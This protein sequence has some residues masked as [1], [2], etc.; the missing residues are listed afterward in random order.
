MERQ[1]LTPR[2]DW[3][4]RCAWL[5]F[6]FH[7]AGGVPYW[8]ESVCYRFTEA[9]IDGLDDLG[10]ELHAM[11][12]EIVDDLVRRG[13]YAGFALPDGAIG[14]I[15]ASWRAREP[16]LHGRFDLSYDGATSPRLLEYNAD[17]PTALLEAAVIQ[18]DWL[19]SRA[20]IAGRGCDQFNSLHERLIARW[21]AMGLGP[22][23]VHFTGLADH[24]EDYGT[25]RYLEDTAR[26]AGLATAFVPI[27]VIGWTGRD[28]VDAAGE[29]IRDL[30]KLYP[31]DW[32]LAENFGPHLGAAPIRLIEPAWKML[33]ANKASLVALW[34]RFP[35]HPALL[36]AAFDRAEIAG[37]AV[38]KPLWGREGANLRLE[39]AGGIIETDGPYGA[40]PMIWQARHD[41]PD[42]GEDNRPLLGLWMVGEAAC[43][44]GVREGLG[45]ITRNTS[46]FVPHYFV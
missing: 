33:L 27:D 45:P 31:W 41:L 16:G 17:T 19:E 25:I 9:E 32:L 43:G 23:R 28:F 3:P 42:M 24:P 34:R 6:D 8:D 13:D 21:G 14:R 15:E 46:R 44:L 35:G 12:L 26:Q 29:V 36:P 11:C 18:W 20:D 39:G 22:G 30:V 2:P 1:R 10:V 4:A 7:S 38:R 37:P 40:G 5:G